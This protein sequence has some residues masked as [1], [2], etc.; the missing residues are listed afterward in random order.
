MPSLRAP[1]NTSFLINLFALDT[2]DSGDDDYDEFL[3]ASTK[4]VTFV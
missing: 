3:L 4:K 1:N 2:F